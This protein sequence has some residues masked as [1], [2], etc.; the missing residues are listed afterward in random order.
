MK[1]FENIKI[2]IGEIIGLIGGYLWASKTKWDDYEPLILLVVSGIGLI[3]SVI[4]KLFSKKKINL[5]F[6]NDYTV[7][8]FIEDNEEISELNGNVEVNTVTWKTKVSLPL[9]KDKP[10]ISI[11]RAN[12][13][14]NKLP[15]ITQI[16][17][18]SFTISIDSSTEA[19]IWNWRAV[20]KLRK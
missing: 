10:K 5:E 19:G 11:N 2:I 8:T 14:Q 17:D 3:I 4:S 12:G 18:D 1:F 9:F 6:H 20:G 15:K 13:Q 7:K 16:T